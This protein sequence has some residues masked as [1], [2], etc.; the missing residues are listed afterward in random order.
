[1]NAPMP[2]QSLFPGAAAASRLPQEAVSTSHL[3]YLNS[4][5]QSLQS[6]VDVLSHTNNLLSDY[7]QDVPRLIT[8]LSSKRHYDV[9]TESKVN[10][11]RKQLQDE[12]APHLAEL[13][14]LSE[15]GVVQEE[16][17]ARRARNKVSYARRVCGWSMDGSLT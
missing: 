12:V 6:T 10:E 17:D 5:L 14:R 4:S 16:A 15:Q 13:I 9:V 1:M 7:V 2:R 3:S 11:A 8:A